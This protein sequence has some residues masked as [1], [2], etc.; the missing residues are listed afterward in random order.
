MG[1]QGDVKR[2]TAWARHPLA[3]V[4]REGILLYV[5]RPLV[6]HYCR[7]RAENIQVLTD[8]DFPVMFVA[9]HSSHL[10]TPCILRVLPK[11]WRRRTAIVAAADYFY[12]NRLIAGLVALSFGT[13]P[14]ERKGGTSPA[15]RARLRK[16][17]HKEK[18]NILMY[19]E[20]TR[21]R[22]GR[23]G[24]VRYGAASLAIEHGVSI[25]PI[26]INGTHEAMPVGKPWPRKHPVTLYFG[27][28]LHP[29]PDEDHKAVTE[30]VRSE[31]VRMRELAAR[32]GHGSATAGR[33]PNSGPG[34]AVPGS[35]LGF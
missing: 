18:W 3:C 14:L 29:R 6:E 5:L 27:P 19:P 13:I 25:V 7:P 11:N 16:L 23:M 31:L 34:G 22:N 24:R 28:P 15:T 12:R 26:F 35:E 20:G 30:R 4:V 33:N 9:N 21:S 1:A 8:V 10:D 2:R 17:L 32:S